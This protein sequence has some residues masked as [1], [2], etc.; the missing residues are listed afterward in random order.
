MLSTVFISKIGKSETFTLLTIYYA[1]KQEQA[2][3][4]VHSHYSDTNRDLVV[5]KQVPADAICVK[6][7]V[8]FFVP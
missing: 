4:T 8:D 1:T 6:F 3:P 7:L 2:K 5:L